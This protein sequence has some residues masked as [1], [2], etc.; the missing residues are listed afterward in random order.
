VHCLKGSLCEARLRV[1]LSAWD[2]RAARWTS[3]GSLLV[4]NMS[5]ILN[6]LK[7]KIVAPRSSWVDRVPWS[8]HGHPRCLWHMYIFKPL[9]SHPRKQKSLFSNPLSSPYDHG[10]LS[11]ST[12]YTT[13]CFAKMVGKPFIKF[14]GIIYDAVLDFYFHSLSPRVRLLVNRMG[15]PDPIREYICQIVKVDGNYPKVIRI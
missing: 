2:D 3:N 6:V 11:N 7:G 8:T 13:L 9:Y 4:G 14:C 15:G 5:R 12:P 10:E 1:Q